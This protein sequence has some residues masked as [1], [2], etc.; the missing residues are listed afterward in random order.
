MPYINTT[1]GCFEDINVCLDTYFFFCCQVG[2]QCNAVDGIEN[3]HNCG[4]C[5]LALCFAGFY[6]GCLRAKVSEKYQ[7]EEGCLTSCICGM[8]C[9]P[10]SVCM[11]GRELNERGTNPG[12]FCCSP[13]SRTGGNNGQ[14]IMY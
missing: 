3:Q 10:C 7:L 8:C 11:T 5:F 4:M 2:R 12:G 1:F 9:G 6:P 14:G 13:P